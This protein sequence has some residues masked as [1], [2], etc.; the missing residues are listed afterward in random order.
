M[1]TLYSRCLNKPQLR[2]SANVKYVTDDTTA[3]PNAPI[4]H[5]GSSLG[6]AFPSF[7]LRDNDMAIAGGIIK[8]SVP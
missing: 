7:F 3:A 5:C 2:D 4:N 1:C 6:S 8:A